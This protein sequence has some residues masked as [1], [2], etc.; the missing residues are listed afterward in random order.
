MSAPRRWKDS[1]DAPIGVR[2]LLSSARPRASMDSVAFE[3]GAKRVAKLGVAPAVAAV[4]VWAKVAAAGFVGVS[5]LTGI[6]WVERF[7][8][9]HED[10]PASPIVAP[11]P[12]PHA[13]PHR[14]PEPRLPDP[15]APEESASPPPS[16]RVPVLP[17]APPPA[18]PKAPA[19][20]NRP[21]QPSIDDV[22]WPSAPPP[23][24]APAHEAS[25]LADELVLLERARRSLSS[26]PRATLSAL[27]E[28]GR[29]FPSGVMAVE[30]ELMTLD[31]L[32]RV[33]RTEEARRNAAA[34]LSRDPTGLHAPRVRA[35]LE[36]LDGAPR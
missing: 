20:L 9:G 13:A 21:S 16:A 17:S 23:A 8:R 6:A 27:D 18:S 36:S 19:A 15:S 33:G 4:S 12:P 2:E 10:A 3:R 30:R 22:A 32:R 31:A 24:E 11:G 25:T 1:P 5:A 14:P 26:D 28:H 29:R 34:W 7:D 35:I